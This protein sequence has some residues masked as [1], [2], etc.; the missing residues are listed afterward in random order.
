M[1]W[2]KPF[3]IGKREVPTNHICEVHDHYNCAYHKTLER[4]ATGHVAMT[5]STNTKPRSLMLASNSIIRIPLSWSDS[6]FN[7]RY[8][9]WA[10]N[11]PVVQS[12]SCPNARNTR[13]QVHSRFHAVPA[14]KCRNR[15]VNPN[16]ENSKRLIVCFKLCLTIRFYRRHFIT[17]RNAAAEWFYKQP[18]MG[19]FVWFIR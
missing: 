10:R 13:I 18:M 15:K 1:W 7:K 3:S 4:R 11:L 16:I 12:T 14:P 17:L 6:D 8:F 5:T 9:L 2:N 19:N